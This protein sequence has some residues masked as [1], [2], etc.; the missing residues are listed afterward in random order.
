[1]EGAQFKT[2]SLKEYPPA[3]CGAIAESFLAAMDCLEAH[4]TQEMPSL[5]LDTVE[6]MRCTDFSTVIGQDFVG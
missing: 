3:F 2:S 1:M 4:P 6:S 5:F